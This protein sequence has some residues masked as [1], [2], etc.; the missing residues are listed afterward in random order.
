MLPTQENPA[1]LY[2]PLLI[3]ANHEVREQA[4]LI[5]CS[6]YG[7]DA[8]LFLRQLLQELEPGTRNAAQ[9]ALLLLDQP[10]QL[11]ET[12]GRAGQLYIE[13][14]GRF[15]L[16]M[17][18]AALS[19]EEW[20]RHCKGRAGVQKAQ[21]LL[22]YLIYCGRRGVS[23]NALKSVIWPSHGDNRRLAATLLALRSL[24]GEFC[25]RDGDQLLLLTADHFVLSPDYYSSDAQQFGRVF[26]IASE[27][28][29]RQG[30]EQAAP[31]YQQAVQLYGGPY[32]HGVA[33]AEAWCRARRDLLA[34][35]F[36]IASER[37]A[38]LAFQQR[39]YQECVNL[40]ELAL[41]SDPLAE[42]LLYWQLRAHAALGQRA[43]LEHSYL[44]YRR[45][46]EADGEG[47]HEGAAQVTA[48]YHELTE[49]PRE[50]VLGGW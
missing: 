15:R 50:Q 24:V 49:P 37:L 27:V 3:S 20:L 44:R 11:A 32:M 2:L 40:C 28:E 45:A 47:A 29:T 9:L 31:F 16:N 46:L 33:G 5:L 25:P 17:G 13:C 38:E 30:L 10:A 14:L 8:T 43:D 23:C 48:V 36:I 12:A 41:E 34:G 1:R 42:E 7:P 22:A 21:S 39:R 19:H 6:L 18:G 4:H 35:N 26:Q